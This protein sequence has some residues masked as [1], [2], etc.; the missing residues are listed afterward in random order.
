[1]GIKD[2]I[3]DLEP[4]SSTNRNMMTTIVST[5]VLPTLKAKR[6]R[7]RKG[8]ERRVPIISLPIKSSTDEQKTP[9]PKI[10]ILPLPDRRQLL[11]KKGVV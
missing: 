4:T 2:R 10:P 6:G 5:I 11:Q 8:Q 3:S 7:P 1:V 9:P